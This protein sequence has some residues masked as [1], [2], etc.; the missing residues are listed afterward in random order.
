[1]SLNDELEAVESAGWKGLLPGLISVVVF[2]ASYLVVFAILD[3]I[4]KNEKMAFFGGLAGA[5]YAARTT[6]RAIDRRIAQKAKTP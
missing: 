2:V 4:S 5:G 1:M 3:S 6:Y